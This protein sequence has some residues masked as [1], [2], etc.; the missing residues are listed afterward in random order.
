MSLTTDYRYE[1]EAA[2]E[3]WTDMR[4]LHVDDLDDLLFFWLYVPKVLSQ[5]GMRLGGHQLRRKDGSYLLT[6]KVHQ[7]DVPLVAFLTAPTT[8]GCMR[9]FVHQLENERVKWVRDKYPW[10]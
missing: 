4:L 1:I 8:T 2:T 5:F 10:N 6:V 7:G 3:Q 9:L